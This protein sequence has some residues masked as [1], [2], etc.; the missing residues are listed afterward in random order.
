MAAIEEIRAR[1]LLDSRGNPTVEVEV[2]LDDGSVG[3]AAVP[4]GASTGTHEAVELRDGDDGRFGGKGVIRACQIVE[5]EIAPEISGLD[6]LEQREVDRLMN[7]LDGTPNK[8]RLGAN[9]T[10]G[11]SLAVAKAAADSLGLS[12]YRY[13]GGPNA[14]V[15]PVPFLNVIN[16]GVHA[17]NGLELQEF[18][19]VPAGAASF[20]EG[21]RWGAEIFHALRAG[22]KA[23]GLSV[24]QGDE[25]GFA[26]NVGTA[27]EALELLLE[28]I[29]GGRLGRLDGDHGGARRPGPDRR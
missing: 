20:G 8:S 19:V 16:G 29:G 7:E 5:E 10:L 17:D 11:V 22:L 6:A 21:I 1:E 12:L 4:S 2:V 13:L 9:A 27:R 26:P 23:K 24:S 25:G 18:M 14:H 3:R 28:A 15:L